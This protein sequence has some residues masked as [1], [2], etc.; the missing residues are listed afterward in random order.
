MI[1]LCACMITLA[2]KH[3]RN[4]IIILCVCVCVFSQMSGKTT[5]IGGLKELLADFKLYNNKRLL[6]KPFCYKVYITHGYCF[7]TSEDN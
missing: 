1:I 4:G 7:Q 2:A 6:L 3:R 5:N